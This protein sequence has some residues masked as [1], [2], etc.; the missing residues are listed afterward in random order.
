[1]SNNPGK[2][3][4]KN[5]PCL[6]FTTLP[7]QIPHSKGNQLTFATHFGLKCISLPHSAFSSVDEF[8]SGL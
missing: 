1:M 3:T 6:S 2:Y 7:H 4:M 5:K 8:I